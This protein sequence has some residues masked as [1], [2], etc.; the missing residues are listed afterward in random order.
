MSG[1]SKDLLNIR[2]NR[3]S[4]VAGIQFELF[5]ILVFAADI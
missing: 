5:N 2:K 1:K 4:G 3:A